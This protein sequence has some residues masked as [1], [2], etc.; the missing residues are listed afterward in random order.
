M[1]SNDLYRGLPHNVIQFTCLQEIVAG[2]LGASL[3]SYHHFSDSL[4]FYES[5]GM[6]SHRLGDSKVPLNSDSLALPKEE[7]DKVFLQLSDFADFVANGEETAKRVLQRLVMLDVPQP[8]RNL[9][10]ILAAEGCRR[11]QAPEDM[12]FALRMCG[13]S[14]LEYMYSRWLGRFEKRSEATAKLVPG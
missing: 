3:G 7:S 4:H 12:N 2:W 10:A 8:F 9:A 13:S 5:D 6:L 14:A 11:R 1:R